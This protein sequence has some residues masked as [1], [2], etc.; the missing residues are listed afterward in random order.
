MAIIGFL[1]MVIAFYISTYV[2]D[3]LAPS[4]GSEKNINKS[5]QLV[6]YSSPPSYIGSLLSFIPVVG[7]LI[8][9]AAWVYGI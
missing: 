2:V 6:A 9:I 8:S 1:S 4:F 5:A 3:A 7:F